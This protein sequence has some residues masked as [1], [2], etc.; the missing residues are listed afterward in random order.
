[1]INLFYIVGDA[2]YV[3]ANHHTYLPILLL[4]GL[5]LTTLVVYVLLLK[6][7]KPNYNMLKKDYNTINDHDTESEAHCN[8]MT[9]RATDSEATTLLS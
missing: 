1:M 9:K 6:K 5:L 4:A 7:V 8:K 3:A 2:A